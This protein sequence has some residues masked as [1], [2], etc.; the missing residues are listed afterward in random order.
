MKTS[1]QQQEGSG[2]VNDPHVHCDQQ[3]RAGLWVIG[4]MGGLGTLALI[5]SIFL[6][7]NGKITAEAAAVGSIIGIVQAAM[8][9]LPSLLG[10]VTNQTHAP[11]QEPQNVNVVNS[12]S[13]PVP[14]EEAEAMK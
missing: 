1:R 4:F 9:G 6:L 12:P 7:W 8:T 2:A 14:V 3:A 10:R 5:G 13:D 11:A